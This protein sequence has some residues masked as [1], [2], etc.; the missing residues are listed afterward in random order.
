M[1]LILLAEQPRV[2]GD[3][4]L[5]GIVGYAPLELGEA[6]AT[7]WLAPMLRAAPLL[8]GIRR[9]LLPDQAPACANATGLFVQG[10]RALAAYNLHYEL[11]SSGPTALACAW[12]LAAGAPNVTFVINHMGSPAIAATPT[13]LDPAWAASMAQLAQ[14]PNV[15][16]KV[17]RWGCQGARK[18]VPTRPRMPMS[19][20]APHTCS[21][22][23]WHAQRGKEGWSVQQLDGG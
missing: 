22:V 11:L 15:N 23:F 9:A 6:V 18:G 14:Y 2:P 5:A 21:T 20:D 19:P 4:E 12:H 8:R 16:V 17:G 3:P 13:G 10:V 1:T 7:Q